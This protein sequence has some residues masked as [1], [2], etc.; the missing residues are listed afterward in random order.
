[1]GEITDINELR[2]GAK[3]GMALVKSGDFDLEV[4]EKNCA[5]AVEWAEKVNLDPTAGNVLTLS[6]IASL[7]TMIGDELFDKPAVDDNG[8]ISEEAMDEAKGKVL[9]VLG[10]NVNGDEVKELN[11]EPTAE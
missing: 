3:A 7:R 5:K 4:F 11:D 2:K 6:V 1:M 10:F 9:K 8:E